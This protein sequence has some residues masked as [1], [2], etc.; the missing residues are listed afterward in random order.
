MEEH[1][2]HARC[3]TTITEHDNFRANLKLSRLVES[4]RSSQEQAL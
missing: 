4:A 2:A 1:A 3:E